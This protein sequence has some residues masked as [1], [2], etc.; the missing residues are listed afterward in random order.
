MADSKKPDKTEE[1]NTDVVNNKEQVKEK[2]QDK[3]VKKEKSNNKEEKRMT[4]QALGMIETRGLVAAIEDTDAMLKAAN[5]ELVGTE[6]IGSG[7]VSV[8]V[9]GDV[10]AVKAAVEA[11]SGSFCGPG[12]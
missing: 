3:E 1:V 11:D 5:V 4:Q 6:K 10:G 9:R 8:M 12:W 7:L 2:A